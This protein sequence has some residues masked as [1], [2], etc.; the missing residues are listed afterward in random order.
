MTFGDLTGTTLRHSRYSSGEHRL[1]PV[2]SE[3]MTVVEPVQRSI[4]TQN[5]AI[6]K[7]P[8]MNA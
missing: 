3:I 5:H 8:D 2:K 6:E 1:T 7:V 4:P